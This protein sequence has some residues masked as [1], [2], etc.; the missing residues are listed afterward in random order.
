MKLK[1]GTIIFS[2]LLGVSAILA[3][4]GARGKFDQVDDGKIVLASSLTSKGAANALQTIVKKYNEVKNIDDYPIEI[5]QIAGGYDG[6]RGNLQTKLSVKD[7]NSFY[8]LILNYPDVV[9]VLG[10]VG[11]ELPFDKVRTDKLSPRFLDF[12]KRISAISKQGI[13]GIPVS[14]S[15]EVL[16]L[17]GPVLHYILSSAKGSSDKTQVSQTSSGSNQQKT[18]QKPL[19]IDTSDSSTSSLWTQ[20]EN[21]AKNN[22]KKANNSK[23]NRR[24][25][26]QS[27][28]T[29]NDQGDASESDKKIKESWGDY[30]EVDGGLKGFTFKASIFDNWHDLLDFSTRAAKSFKKIKDNNT[31]KGTD[32]Q[33]I[34]GVDS[35]ANSLFTSVFAAG[36]GDYD[37]FFYKVA[38]GRADFSNFKN[39]GSS[40]QNLQSVFNDYKG[41]IDQN[42][43]FVNKGG[44]YSSNFQK[45]HQL[46]Y[47]ISSTSGF[48][49]SF[50]GN[51]AK[52]LKFG[53][54]SFIEYPQYTVP[55][56]APSKNGDGN[57]TN[58]NSDLLGT[59]TLSSVKKS[60]DKSKSDSQQNQGKKVEGTPNQGKKAEGA[61][62]QGKKENNSTTIEIYKNKIPD[63]KNAGK[64]AILIKDNNLIKQLEDAA[65]KNG[66][67]SNQKQ[68]GESNV[69]KEQIIGYTTTGNVREDGNHIFRV[70]KINDEQYDRKIIVGVTVE[71]LEQS[72]TLQSEE[73][74]VLAAP[75]K[76]KSTDKK[77][78]TITQGPNIIGIHANEKENAETQK[79]VDWFL[80]TEVDWPAKENSSNK[81]DQQNSTKKQTAAE[82]FVESASYILPLKEIFENKE[83]KENTSNSDKNKSSS[84]RK[85]TYAEKALELF[86]QISKDE[87]VSYSDP[88]DFRSGK[89]RD[90]IGSNFNAAVSSK[91]DFNKFVKGFIATLGSEI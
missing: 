32:I 39:R 24:S 72:S 15:T 73:A 16:V 68:G 38:N 22:G 86:Q 78:V 14:L 21:A 5:I 88:S 27:T 40:F 43:L 3:A 91:A 42:G 69:Q 85:N 90:G 79:F 77:K 4:C 70:D 12:N 34:L 54:N 87:I 61:Q 47:S 66:A 56:K 82:F 67:E 75:G 60:T 41:L 18:L 89:F 45:F 83:K 51:S 63:G 10:R 80:N 84:Q 64:D 8:N 53:D 57:S 46:A 31:K 37:N 48:Y 26:D 11:M 23:S 44:S 17:N 50:A 81:Q 9:S 20:I 55:I 30:E 25:T 35:S 71:T 36:N 58:S 74:I 13:Y 76:Y 7:K 52:R 2:G 28:Q 33:G 19:K 62:N 1:Y 65:K 59:F 29:H 6:G 49:Y